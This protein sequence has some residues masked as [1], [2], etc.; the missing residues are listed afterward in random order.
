MKGTYKKQRADKT[1]NRSSESHRFESIHEPGQA[2][3]YG[4]SP[5]M[6]YKYPSP[7]NKYPISPVGYNMANVMQMLG[8]PYL[9]RSPVNSAI[10][11]TDQRSR[12]NSINSFSSSR[13]FLKN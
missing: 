3:A 10:N 13:R 7:R 1:A 8:I 4:P 6:L 9:N 2:V 12:P 11:R 5:Q